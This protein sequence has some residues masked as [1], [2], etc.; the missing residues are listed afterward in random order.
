MGGADDLEGWREWGTVLNARG[1]SRSHASSHE[2]GHLP[3]A[4]IACPTDS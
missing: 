2:R 4:R 1:Q 3:D